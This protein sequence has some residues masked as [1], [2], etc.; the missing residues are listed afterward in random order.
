MAAPELIQL[1]QEEVVAV[2]DDHDL[3]PLDNLI[4]QL[5]SNSNEQHSEAELI[6]GLC[7]QEDP[8]TLT[9]KLAQILQNSHNAAAVN[10]IERLS[11]LVEWLVT[12]LKGLKSIPRKDSSSL[13]EGCSSEKSFP[14]AT[15]L[16]LLRKALLVSSHSNTQLRNSALLLAHMIG[17]SS[18]VQ[19]LRKLCL[20]GASN[21]VIS[22]E[23]S[24]IVSSKSDL[25]SNKADS[26][27][28]AAA[29]LEF[30]KNLLR[31]KSNGLKT[32]EG[33]SRNSN[34]WVVA[35][36]WNSCPI[37]MLPCDIGSSG[38]LPVLDCDDDHKKVA[39]PLQSE[40]QRV[41]NEGTRKRGPDCDVEMLE[42]LNFKKMRE[43]EEAL[44]LNGGDDDYTMTMSDGVKGCLMIS[45]VWKKVGEEELRAMASAVRILV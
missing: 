27:R 43:N 15:L 41:P 42:N 38:R 12:T 37:G 14:K 32:S 29:N 44:G 24:L 45:G 7:K 17:N 18:L 33:V 20:V 13:T 22:E 6:Y 21:P 31:M 16:R 2:L 30:I 25:V 11:D 4:S 3:N 1:Q 34:S 23:S 35:K 9:I 28:E 36:S 5:M 40:E 19:K 10:Q 39:K 8:N 26:L